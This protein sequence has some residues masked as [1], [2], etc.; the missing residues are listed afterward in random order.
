[1]HIDHFAAP[2]D[3]QGSNRPKKAHGVRETEIVDAQEV[4]WGIS[5]SAFV[6]ECHT[7]DIR[8]QTCGIKKV[9]DFTAQ[10]AKDYCYHQAPTY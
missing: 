1:M 4:A 2:R 6:G 10:E 7:E 8:K 9:V 5:E 3:R